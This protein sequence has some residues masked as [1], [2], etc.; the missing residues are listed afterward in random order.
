MVVKKRIVKTE[1]I[2]NEEKPKNPAPEKPKVIISEKKIAPKKRKRKKS[3]AR[4]IIKQTV[5][6]SDINVEKL[7]IEN[8]VS[9]QKVMTAMAGKFDSLSTQMSKLLEL[10]EI[11]AKSFAEKGFSSEEDKKALDKLDI[12]LEQNKTLAK[13]IALLHERENREQ[14][15]VM[16]PRILPRPQPIYSPPPQQAI[17]KIVKTEYHEPLPAELSE[18]PQFETEM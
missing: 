3:S 1:T 15:V 12:L 2:I 13:G 17:K 9:L 14:E 4:K 7:L 11:S 8:F 10:F 16:P 5:S 18:N 6:Q